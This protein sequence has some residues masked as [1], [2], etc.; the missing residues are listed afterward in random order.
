[1]RYN[2]RTDKALTI[3]EIAEQCMDAVKRS[4][5]KP[6]DRVIKQ[7]FLVS[8]G[9]GDLMDSKGRAPN[10]KLNHLQRMTLNLMKDL[11]CKQGTDEFWFCY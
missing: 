9:L 10:Y 2:P 4:T 6:Y 3:D 7:L 8:C 5:P 11:E 1:M